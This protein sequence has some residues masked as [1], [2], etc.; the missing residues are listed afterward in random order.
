MSSPAEPA[1][2]APASGLSAE[3]SIARGILLHVLAV[4]GFSVMALIIKLLEGRY[5][6]SQIILFRCW[7]ALIP[8]LLYLPMQGGWSAL[9]TRSP[10]WQLVRTGSGVAAMYVGFFALSQMAFADYV[11]ITFTAPLFATLLSIPLLGE[12]VGLWRLGAVAVGFLG[13]VV[14]L[15]PLAGAVDPI[16]LLALGSAFGYGVAMIAMRKVAATDQSA[17][18]VLYFTLTGGVVALF[19]VPGQW[20]TPDLPDLLFLISLGLIGGVAQIIMTEA[21]RHAPPSS[22]APFDY[23]A[24]LWAVTFGFLVFGTVPG[25]NVWIGGGLICASGLYIIHRERVRGV[26]RGKIKGSS[27]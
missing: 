24:M 3:G 20:V 17:A 9:K 6:T 18:T 19:S 27:L 13:A 11:A 21:F 1:A 8:L 10:I 14:T 23:T 4:A 16:A 2:R 12:K 25:M 22:L 5:P 7:P 15:G 26:R